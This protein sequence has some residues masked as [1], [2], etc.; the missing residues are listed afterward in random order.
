MARKAA[1]KFMMQAASTQIK[2]LDD[3]PSLEGVNTMD[4]RNGIAT[5]LKAAYR[6]TGMLLVFVF[7]IFFKRIQIN[8][9]RC[10]PLSSFDDN[11]V[12]RFGENS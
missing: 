5:P 1:S 12:S 10:R 9:Y 6:A 2:S 4:D 3:E 11:R 7:V 8:L